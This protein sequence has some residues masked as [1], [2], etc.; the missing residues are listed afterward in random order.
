MLEKP[1]IQD[2]TIITCL[3]REYGLQISGFAFLPLG[4]DLNT[5]VYRA[6]SPGGSAYFVKLRSGAPDDIIVT[7]PKVFYDQGI[8]NIIP[9]LPTR[10]GQLWAELEPFRLILY[11]FIDGCDG[12]GARLSDDHWRQLGAALRRIHTLALSPAML[13]RIPPTTASA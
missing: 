9:P 3:Q 5:A 8:E 4:A 11:P 6:V 2:E 1:G 13:E 10:S 12:Y 7:L